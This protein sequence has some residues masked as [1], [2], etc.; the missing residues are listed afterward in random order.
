MS[1]IRSAFERGPAFIPYLVTGDPDIKSSKRYVEALDRGGADVIE[2][3]LP[4][5]EPI[6]EG[7][8]IQRAIDRSLEAGMTPTRYF[9]FVDQLE[10][11]AALVCMTYYNLLL[12][13]SPRPAPA[14]FVERAAQ[15]GIDGLIIPDLPVE[16]SDDLA[17]ACETYDL[18]LIQLV[19]PTTT[20][21]RRRRIES[22]TSGFVYVQARLGTTGERTDPDAT[23]ERSLGH[24]A[25]WDVPAAVGF[26]ID[27]PS[28]AARVIEA[29]ADGVVVGSAL[30]EHLEAIDSATESDGAQSL[31]RKTRAFTEAIAGA[32]SS[33]A[34]P[35]ADIL[36]SARDRTRP[37]ERVEV[38][39]RSL[40]QA[41]ADTTNA[42]HVPVIA[43]LK[44]TSPTTPTYHDVDA[45]D[46]A[47]RMV[48]AGATAISVLTEPDHFGG[49]PA[50]LTAV[51]EAV[52]VP[53]L[54]KDFVFEE[55]ELD[56]V[57]ADAVLL[58]ARFVDDLCALVEAART[59]G[60][61]PLVE[62]HI[63]DELERAHRAGASLVGIN[64]RDLTTL[65]ID[66][67]TFERVAKHASPEVTLIAESGLST[68]RDIERMLS[69][70]ADGVLIG[71]A[72]MEGDVGRNVSRLVESPSP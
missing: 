22:R 25:D 15:V 59:R 50:E 58:I 38:A 57:P 37:H 55:A 12:N 43:E 68:R 35:V 56:R 70:G 61:E 46:T 62:V 21:D 49:D 39:S 54:R 27:S 30:I 32:D 31:D 20:A 34:P 48:D 7:P 67:D 16:E 17:E 44:R 63:R 14:G 3:G 69:A 65:S 1:R 66:R 72:V 24:V 51:R 10:V 5:S 60:M 28:L 2:L 33:L 41:L 36:Q 40:R 47:H 53:I 23:L 42:G 45:V 52:E 29:G 4:F 18:D 11:D 6:A 8:V 71:T 26:G 13:G 19:A 9:A 64:N